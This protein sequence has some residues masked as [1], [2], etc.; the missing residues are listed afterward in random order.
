MYI[1]LKKYLKSCADITKCKAMKY[2]REYNIFISS[3]NLQVN[4]QFAAMII[5]VS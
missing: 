3:F 2:I 1:E 4:F 5:L